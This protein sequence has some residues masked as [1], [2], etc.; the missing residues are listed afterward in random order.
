[1][2]QYLKTRYPGISQHVGPIGT[3]YGISYDLRTPLKIF[4]AEPTLFN[5]KR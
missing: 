1:M 4:V 2:S 3:V 5:F